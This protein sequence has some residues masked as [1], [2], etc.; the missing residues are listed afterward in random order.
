[1]KGRKVKE[2]QKIWKYREFATF[3]KPQKRETNE[4]TKEVC[5]R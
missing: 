2:R 1:M 4:L 5:S 3:V